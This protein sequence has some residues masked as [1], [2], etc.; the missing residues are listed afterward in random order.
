MN[1]RFLEELKNRIDI[2]EVVR[3]YAEL[4]KS[5]KNYMC[6]SPFRNERTPSFCVSSDKQFWYDFGNSEGGDVISFLE[7]IEN[8]SF[9]EAV[10]MLAEMANLEVPKNISPQM[11]KEEKQDIF[12]LHEAACVFFE[13]QLSHSLLA[14]NYLVQRKISESVQ[15]KWRLGYGGSDSQGLTKY[16]LEKGFRREQI[17]TSGVAFEQEFGNKNM[18]DRFWDRLIFPI[19]DGKSDK[20]VAF[21]GRDLSGKK[22]VAKYVNSPENPVYHKSSTLFGLEKARKHIRERDKIIFVEGYFDVISAHEHGFSH[23]VATCGTAL[24]Q[25]HILLIKRLTQNVYLAFDSDRAGKLA[26]IRATEICLEHEITPFIIDIAEGKDFDE[27]A[28]KDPESLKRAVASAENALFFLLERFAIKFLDGSL[29]SEKKFLDM[30][31]ELL[32]FVSRPIEKDA[33]LQKIS[34]RTKR[35]KSIIEEEFFRFEKKNKREKKKVAT[36]PSQPQKFSR[37]ESFVGFLSAYWRN[38]SGL[39]DVLLIRVC[40][41]L[42]AEPRLLLE[43]KIRNESFSDEEKTMLVSWE[44]HQELLYGNMVSEEILKRD[45]QT[46]LSFFEQEATKKKRLSDAEQVRNQ[47]KSQ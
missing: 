15:K 28:K 40:P 46:F 14:K 12:A 13:Q 27:F 42:S 26:T 32:K 11:N 41:L 38:F 31:F 5:G 37:E 6:R 24:T 7:K 35:G 21:S 33:V 44:L 25:E 1:D 17:A 16:L 4:K 29:E 20:I 43:K 3:K 39:S 19:F 45:F 34:E 47:I 23:T 9:H 2:V 30:M 10:E 22:E 36:D 8:F 18:K